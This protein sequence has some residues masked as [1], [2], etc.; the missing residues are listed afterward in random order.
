MHAGCVMMQAENLEV[1]SNAVMLLAYLYNV[2]QPMP[3]PVMS[4]VICGAVGHD[5]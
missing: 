1:G 3:G 5:T 4:M 2:V